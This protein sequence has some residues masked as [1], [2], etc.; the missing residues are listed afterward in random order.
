MS[1]IY[2]SPFPQCLWPVNAFSVSA[3]LGDFLTPVFSLD[4]CHEPERCS[5]SVVY[6]KKP[7]TFAVRWRITLWQ[8]VS[9]RCSFSK[10][11]WDE[12]Q[13][14]AVTS[15]MSQFVWQ[16]DKPTFHRLASLLWITF[17]R[18]ITLEHVNPPLTHLLKTDATPSRMFNI[19]YCNLRFQGYM[20]ASFSVKSI[21]IL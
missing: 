9:G 12:I 11:P 21:Q 1:P 3:C 4:D 16:P 19:T 7:R 14:S 20:L 8:C 18:S 10:F 17:P 2:S 15:A 5:G 13:L 6:S